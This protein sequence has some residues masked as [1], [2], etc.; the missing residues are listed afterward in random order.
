MLSAGKDGVL[1]LL[2]G[3]LVGEY[4][5]CWGEGEGECEG[6]I[7]AAIVSAVYTVR[8]LRLR[9]AQCIVFRVVSF[10]ATGYFQLS[11]KGCDVIKV[12]TELRTFK[13][14]LLRSCYVRRGGA[15]NID[16][17][18]SGCPVP[19]LQDVGPQVMLPHRRLKDQPP[20]RT[21]D[22]LGR[23]TA[24]QAAKARRRARKAAKEEAED[25]VKGD[26]SATK[27]CGRVVSD[28]PQALLRF[29]ALLCG[30]ETN[31]PLV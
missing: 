24:V 3:L 23:F 9:V 7:T 1:G 8:L 13:P 29:G 10:T 30:V 20:V 16:R 5:E 31:P 14:S 25:Q 2:V 11:H 15:S 6:D 27:A 19:V 17:T 26:G 22:R 12:V 28:G 4:C 21:T 18:T